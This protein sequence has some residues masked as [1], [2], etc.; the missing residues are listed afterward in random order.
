MSY[1]VIYQALQAYARRGGTG[2][3][4]PPE[5]IPEREA[6]M[7]ALATELE[8]VL[9]GL[10]G[11][12]AASQLVESQ[13]QFAQWVTRR[14]IQLDA[15]RRLGAG[16]SAQRDLDQIKRQ[17]EEVQQVGLRAFH[18]QLQHSLARQRCG[19]FTR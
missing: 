13:R 16:A 2:G 10:A 18:G 19:Q 5:H 4:D 7:Q 9:A 12:D 8:Q 1:T 15:S 11:A 6:A 14:P 17:I 3:A